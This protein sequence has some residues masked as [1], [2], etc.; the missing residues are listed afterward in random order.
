MKKIIFFMIIIIAF[1]SRLNCGLTGSL[2]YSHNP[3]DDCVLTSIDYGRSLNITGYG[4]DDGYRIYNFGSGI[5][6]NQGK[7][8]LAYDLSIFS[9]LALYRVP[10]KPKIKDQNDQNFVYDL[11]EHILHDGPTYLTFS[12]KGPQLC[13][14]GIYQKDFNWSS[15]GIDFLYKSSKKY[16]FYTRF[17]Y[18][19]AASTIQNNMDYFTD[20]DVTNKTNFCLDMKIKNSTN[21]WIPFYNSSEWKLETYYR[22]ILNDSKQKELGVNLKYE[23]RDFFPTLLNTQIG[24]IRY[25][26]N[27]NWKNIFKCGIGISYVLHN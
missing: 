18:I 6:I 4:A 24:Y 8:V 13:N 10:L 7:V 9:Y 17:S 2:N 12:Y 14:I 23:Y 5:S 20:I 3:I 27:D 11:D 1:S 16:E 22:M 26:A 25:G 21:L 19:I 15:V